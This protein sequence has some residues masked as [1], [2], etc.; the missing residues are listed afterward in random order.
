MASLPA[1]RVIWIPDRVLNGLSLR[2]R[3]ALRCIPC[4]GD[5]APADLS[6]AS[7]LNELKMNYVY[8]DLETFSECD[9]RKCGAYRYAEDSTTEILLWGYA[10]G[11]EPARVWDLTKTANM[12]AD[13]KAALEAVA[14]SEAKTV[15]HN[16]MMFDRL[17]LDRACGITLKPE[18]VVDTMVL[19][20]ECGLPG[21]LADLSAIFRLDKDHAKDLDGKRLVQ[22]FCKPQPECRKVRRATRHTHPEDWAKFV[23]YCRLD[24]EAERVLFKRMPKFN[25]TAEERA[26]QC[27]D[28]YINDHGIG[29][30][31]ELAKAAVAFADKNKA[32]LNARAAEITG[33]AVYS[34]SQTAAMIEAIEN[35]FG[36]KLKSLQKAEVN[37]LLETDELPEPLRE[38][39]LVRLNT[40][41]SS[42]TK[43]KAVLNAVCADGRLHGCLQFR[44]AA[45]TGRFSGRLFQPQNLARPT[46]SQKEIDFAITVAKEGEL[47]LWFGSKLPEALS[48]CLRGVIT[49]KRGYRLVVADYSNIE[50]R[51][52][53][54]LAGESWKLKAFHEYDIVMGADGQ[55]LEPGTPEFHWTTPR[56]YDDKG[57]CIHKG[58][59]LYK[60]TYSKAFN[61]PVEKVTKAQRQMG[62]VLELAMGY[63]G[64]AGAFVTFAKGYG[65]DLHD[66]A[67]A[68]LPVIPAD[69]MGEAVDAYE[70]A[71]EQPFRICGLSREVWLACDSVKRLWRRANAN[72]VRFWSA[73]G[74]A[75]VTAIKEN[76]KVAIRGP[77]PLTV[78]KR[79]SWLL[80]RLPSGR[81]L[82][83]ASPRLVDGQSES[84]TYMGV[85]QRT[86]KWERLET[87][88]GKTVE[89]ITQA[90]A[91]DILTGALP[92]LWKA[93]FTPVLTIHDEVITDCMD[94]DRFSHERM[95]ALM[96]ELPSWGKGL[97][98]A[99]AGY[100]AGRYHK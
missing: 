10:V 87:Y 37:R 56:R 98:L 89:N 62:K 1:C 64:G 75:C 80:L 52:L 34:A 11:D 85:N 95:E 78:E 57:E 59:D 24:V 81:F 36:V 5:R 7:R 83:Y 43:F 90:V 72:V 20:Y 31:T 40:A 45:R 68:V 69:V 33:G 73:V 39:L 4:H 100:E 48:N 14:R 23:N 47:D 30:D 58:H 49:A 88:P 54:W 26:L 97:P 32:K 27:L 96:C 8:M 82:C 46:M 16:G 29:V 65:I 53:A 93:G 12:P 70:W 22:L 74:E 77:R 86:R 60:L 21:S 67:K 91:A 18:D 50:G 51:V 41:K 71:R 9:L 17:V 99:A 55:W 94:E 25:V 66:M 15:W 84:W 38:L 79:G 42:V 44:G 35:Q 13:L 3:G 92:R 2:R 19:A 28:A 63:G 6:Q 61:V 76:R